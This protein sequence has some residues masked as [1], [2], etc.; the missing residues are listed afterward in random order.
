MAEHKRGKA[1][2]DAKTPASINP[3]NKAEG[4]PDKLTDLDFLTLE[5]MGI[6]SDELGDLLDAE[7]LQ[8]YYAFLHRQSSD[9]DTIS[10]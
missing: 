1:S 6:S 8:A 7:E 5:A 2:M 4:Q 9:L 10:P 3:I